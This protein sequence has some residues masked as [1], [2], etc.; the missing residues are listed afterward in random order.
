MS[1]R[2]VIEQAKGVFMERY[3]VGEEGAFARLVALSQSTNV[4][5]VQ[6]ATD[7]VARSGGATGAE[8]GRSN[9]ID[10]ALDAFGEPAVVVSPI[11][12][13]RGS[14]ADFQI[15][16]VN[17]AAVRWIGRP[18]D[19][20][21]RATTASIYPSAKASVLINVCRRALATGTLVGAPWPVADDETQADADQRRPVRV[22]AARVSTVVLVTWQ[23]LSGRVTE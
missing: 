7:V 14:V 2:A 15:D 23:V 22:H 13:E 19:R 11:P 8:N 12:T 4:K 18:R 9:W 5:L 10:R 6:I 1:R 16:H 21:L 3:G 20:M 17:R